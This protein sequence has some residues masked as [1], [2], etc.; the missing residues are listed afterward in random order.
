[1]TFT[2]RV[3]TYVNVSSLTTPFNF[4]LTKPSGTVDGDILFTLICIGNG[5]TN[6]PATIDSVP[7][8]WNLIATRLIST[9]YRYY[10]YWHIA[11]GDGS[12]Y[13]WSL[14]A[15][16]KLHAVCSCYTGGDFNPADPID[17]YSDTQ[18]IT[19]DTILRATSFNVAT[20]NSPLFFTGGVYST[21]SKTFTKPSVPTS[22]WVE[23]DDAGSTTPDWWSE[24][25]SMIWAG[26][27]ATGNIQA[28]ISATMTIKHAFAVALNPVT[29]PTYIS[30][31]DGAALMDSI[32]K[33]RR[34][35]VSDATGLAEV[36]MRTDKMFPVLDALGLLDI[37]LKQRT[38]AP[39]D[40]ATLLLDSTLKQREV[41]PIQDSLVLLDEVFKDRYLSAPD[42]AFLVDGVEVNYGEVEVIVI[43]ALQ[44]VDEVYKTRETS[45]M[46]G[47]TLLDDMA[48]T[49]ILPP[50][51]DTLSLADYLYA[52]KPIILITDILSQLD[53]PFLDKTLTLNEQISLADTIMKKVPGEGWAGTIAGIDAP[54]KIAGVPRTQI[55][56]IS[57]SPP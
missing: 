1:M 3:E 14:T 26:S 22:G 27:G 21:A 12:S 6:P 20:A 52:D 7:A 41:S 49:R 38:L 4:S 55:K 2:A 9:Y 17:N 43:D 46:D 50:I 15:T 23:D 53:S 19:S 11:S 25:C 13:T 48:K 34:F 8:N 5:T 56:R 37:I 54:E 31:V 40:D 47:I 32:G 16:N 39:I 29:A 51:G 35:T 28:T 36:P 42:D 18:Y 33:E 24:A 45:I 10:F 30:V 57:G 44:L